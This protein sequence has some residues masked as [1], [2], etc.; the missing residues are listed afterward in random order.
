MPEGIARERKMISQTDAEASW[1]LVLGDEAVAR[2]AMDCGAK[3]HGYPGT[4]WTE[5]GIYYFQRLGTED[6]APNEKVAAEW[7]LGE[8]YAGTRVLVGAK[9]VG[10]NVGAEIIMNARMTGVN[11]GMILYS[12]DDPSMHSSQNEQDNRYYA[13]M[14]DIP[15][16]EPTDQH[17]MYE[18]TKAAFLISEQL[19]LPILLRTTTR[20]AHNR[21]IIRVRPER[22]PGRRAL[23]DDR[24]RWVVLPMNARMTHERLTKIDLEVTLE[25]AAAQLGLEINAVTPGE[26]KHLGIITSGVAHGYVLRAMKDLGIAGSIPILRIGAYPAQKAVDRFVADKEQ[27][28][29]VEEGGPFIETRLLGSAAQTGFVKHGKLDHYLPRVGEMTPTSVRSG[30]ARFAM[31]DAGSAVLIL[32]TPYPAHE[33]DFTDILAPRPPRLCVGCSHR[34]TA[35]ALKTAIEDLDPAR[36]QTRVF[37]DIGCYTLV[38]IE[39]QLL[40]TTVEMGAS[41]GMAAGAAR[42]GL[43]YA[44]GFI[45]DSTF[46]HSGLPT[47]VAAVQKN[48]PMTVMISDNGTT[49]MTGMEKVPIRDSVEQIVRGLGVDPEHVAVITPTDKKH[50]GNVQIIK[51]ELEYPGLS[52][53]I[54]KR[55]CMHLASAE[56]AKKSGPAQAQWIDEYQPLPDAPTQVPAVDLGLVVA[57]VGGQGI[58]AATEILD[59]GMLGILKKTQKAESGRQTLYLQQPEVHGMAQRGGSV[60]TNLRIANDRVTAGMIGDYEADVLL[61]FD[62]LE[63]ARNIHLMAQTGTL[64]SSVNLFPNIE[65]PHRQKIL[66]RLLQ[67]PRHILLD[68][69]G[70]AKEAGTE[71]AQNSVMLGAFGATTGVLPRRYL[72]ALIREQYQSKRAEIVEANVKAFRFGWDAARFYE[73][74]R[75]EGMAPNDTYTLVLR[76]SGTSFDA[77]LAGEWKRVMD[78]HGGVLTETLL[79]RRRKLEADAD[80]LDALLAAP[81]LS[82]DD[83]QKMIEPYL[84]TVGLKPSAEPKIPRH[85]ALFSTVDH[86]LSRADAEGRTSLYEH[87][88]AQIYQACEALEPPHFVFVPDSQIDRDARASLS[89]HVVV[90]IVADHLTHKTGLD[91]VRLRVPAETLQATIDAMRRNFPEQY[92]AEIL[93]DPAAAPE[94]YKPFLTDEPDAAGLRKAV[95][96]SIRGMFISDFYPHDTNLGGEIQIGTKLDPTFGPV[97]VYALGGVNADTFMQRGTVKKEV[98]S[99]R[100]LGLGEDETLFA[101]EMICETDLLRANLPGNRRGEQFEAINPI[102]RRLSKAIQQVAEIARHYSREN[103]EAKYHIT[104]FEINPVADGN[105]CLDGV[106]HFCTAREGRFGSGDIQA[107]DALVDWKTMVLAGLSSARPLP[108]DVTLVKALEN[109]TPMG[110]LYF[111][112]PDPDKLWEGLNQRYAAQYTF[113]RARFF[114]TSSE[115]KEHLGGRRLDL[116]FCAVPAG[117]VPALVAEAVQAGVVRAI[118]IATAGLGET[119]AGREP[120]KK[121]AEVIRQHDTRVCGP[122]NLGHYARIDE[123]VVDTLFA[124]VAYKTSATDQGYADA[125]LVCQSGARAITLRS[126]LRGVVAPRYVLTTG[127]CMDLSASDYL[128]WVRD[129]HTAAAPLNIVAFYIE[130][131]KPDEGLIFA[132][133]AQKMVAEGKSI[134]VHYAGSTKEASVLTETHTGRAAGDR[135]VFVGAM[136]QVGAYVTDNLQEFEDMIRMKACLDATTKVCPNPTRL[137][138]I[139]GG[140]NAGFEKC[141]I[142]GHIVAGDGEY[143]FRLANLS[144]DTNAAIHDVLG[145]AE[146]K[147]KITF[148]DQAQ[149]LDFSPQLE[150]ARCIEVFRRVL[151]DPNTDCAI[152]SVVP[153]TSALNTLPAGAGHAEDFTRSGSLI[154]GFVELKR[155]HDK[156]FVVSISEGQKH[157]AAADFLNEN[158]VATF[159]Y[160]DRATEI[161]GRYMQHRVREEN[162]RSTFRV[163]GASG[164]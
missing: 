3:V 140:S 130:S 77:A 104:K 127:N 48:T 12:A 112:A 147:A 64:I 142:A 71:R 43:K 148:I 41:I 38:A 101:N 45:G 82:Q 126:A 35:N 95:E 28:L 93:A 40:D 163:S 26:L 158:G 120:Q 149:I 116:L 91:A 17:E 139:G 107:I 39:H 29:V 60:L 96:D 34:D 137:P 132:R 66:D 162:V 62:I 9:H 106:L 42:S 105:V 81:V 146:G 157:D 136:E 56:R 88:I 8:S 50:D 32:A 128:A 114:S 68:A 80:L 164:D 49:A 33:M 154:R 92:A 16:L 67:Y 61:S 123:R 144:A 133:L 161:L 11:G 20:L 2:A 5:A 131:L 72:E 37:G 76:L 6:W 115:L 135:D 57:G 86:L 51:R 87:E 153:E 90:K 98:L 21:A 25:G 108:P 85:D 118:N 125:V 117:A 7:A 70:L 111:L 4:P 103:P 152:L 54:S 14:A 138:A 134:L 150:D 75:N 27:V 145:R 1:L 55:S 129:K 156:P 83:T 151:E 100:A 30:V 31:H 53:V 109:G 159:R 10:W 58:L 143:M 63:T 141:A 73:A 99:L 69:R 13:L 15:C 47:L 113:D 84:E 160:V 89:E 94:A 44:I 36:E 102:E 24:R 155:T 124:P 119:A 22:D 79:A 97:I 46:V 122:N 59:R 19:S 52:V 23:A 74:C 65:Y 121:L 110:N 78:L 18:W